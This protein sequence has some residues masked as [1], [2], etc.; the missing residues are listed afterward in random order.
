MTTDELTEPLV[1]V[2]VRPL[3]ANRAT[4]PAQPAP[5]TKDEA[6]DLALEALKHLQPTA[7]TS[8]YTIGARDKAITA[9][10]QARALD[11][12]AE[13]AR[14]LGLDYEPVPVQEF[15]Y[16]GPEELWLQ[17]HGDC[18]DDELTD[19][20]DYTDDSVTWCWHQINN[21]DVRYVR[22]DIAT[23]PAQPA[24]VQSCYCPNCEAMG[25]ELA[26]LKAQPAPVQE[27]V[28][29]RT[30]VD[31]WQY[32]ETA[33]DGEAL[34]LCTP[35]A[36]QRQWVG[37]DDDDISALGLSIAKAKALESLLKRRNT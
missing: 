23:P 32:T 36:A 18:S 29:Y 27:P 31:G 35:P 28:A 20:V 12:M 13:N 21:S 25:K 26:A 6:L 5:I 8:F 17:L 1:C 37:L 10:K 19:P 14:A 4:P 9:I 22:A 33:G 11:K 3:V 7:L 30:W 16:K 2:V 34:C 24:P 15:S